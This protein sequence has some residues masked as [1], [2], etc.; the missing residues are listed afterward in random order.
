GVEKLP[1]AAPTT[2]SAWRL[3]SSDI[4]VVALGVCSESE[5]MVILPI[6]KAVLITPLIDDQPC[7]NWPLPVER[8][9]LASKWKFPARVYSV[10]PP[11]SLSTKNPPPWIAASKAPPVCWMDPWLK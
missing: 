4:L 8:S 11:A 7:T 6:G 2:S 1:L 10:L 9:P 5:G 3:T